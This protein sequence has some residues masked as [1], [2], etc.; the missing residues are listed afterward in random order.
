MVTPSPKEGD[1]SCPPPMFTVLK[2]MLKEG[3][4]RKSASE[5]FGAKIV[6]MNT[7][8]GNNIR[9]WSFISGGF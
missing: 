6:K 9:Y 7:R 2:L 4:K 1:D 8:I 3:E 5:V